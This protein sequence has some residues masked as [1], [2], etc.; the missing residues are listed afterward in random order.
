MKKFLQ[1][2]F[3]VKNNH[4]HKVFTIC[5]IKLKFRCRKPPED[6]KPECLSEMEEYENLRLYLR[7]KHKSCISDNVEV[8]EFTYGF[9]EFI[10]HGKD[11]KLKIG[12]FCSL[13]SGIKVFL[14]GDHNV[15]F[16]TT[17]PFNVLLPHNFGDIIGHPVSKGDVIIGND[18]WIASDATIMSGVRIG[19]GA[20]VANK[21][22]VTKD[23][24][25]YSIVG[26][27]PAKVIR[28]R[29]DDETIKRLLEIQWWNWEDKH[30]VNAIRMLQSNRIE[31]LIE[32]YYRNVM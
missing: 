11:V 27:V 8:G 26:G 30:I 23:V 4:F 9:P 25:P 16:V 19:D 13:A 24:P 12:K 21:A 2:I 22:L 6:N 3:S 5:G 10:F 20:V 18:V 28:K 29:F 31:E 32:Y 14:K 15:D 1:L 7:E 17:Y